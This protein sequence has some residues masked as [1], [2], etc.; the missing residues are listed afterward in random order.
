MLI[1]TG[2]TVG[3]GYADAMDTVIVAPEAAESSDYLVALRAAAAGN[4]RYRSQ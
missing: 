4:R 3:Y 1:N 2:D